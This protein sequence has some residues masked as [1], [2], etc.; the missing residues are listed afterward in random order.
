MALST[1]RPPVADLL[2]HLY[3]RPLHPELFDILAVRKVRH[4]DYELEVR[5]TRT[6]HVISWENDDVHLSEVVAASD[7]PMPVKRRLISQRVRNEQYP[8]FECLHGIRYQAGV[9]VEVLPFDLF[10]HVQEE[11]VADGAKR[12]LLLNFPTCNRLSVAPVGFVN[13][14]ARRGCV[15]LSS[16][17]T[18]PGENTVVKTQSFIEKKQESGFRNQDSGKPG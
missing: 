14:E 2:F 9:Q 12:G 7:Q 8:Q 17:H 3:A 18:F 13:V 4:E 15:F 10:Q 1:I 5:I 16:F 6:G 11:I